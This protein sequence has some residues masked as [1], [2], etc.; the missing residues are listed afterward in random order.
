MIKA[1]ILPNHVTYSVLMNAYAVHCD[2]KRYRRNTAD[3]RTKHTRPRAAVT[4]SQVFSYL[5]VD[6]RKTLLYYSKMTNNGLQANQFHYSI[7]LRAYALLGDT[8]KFEET[9]RCLERFPLGITV[10]DCG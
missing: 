1:G 7:L 6:P 4:F 8:K 5:S 3:T 9:L 2:N 10:Y